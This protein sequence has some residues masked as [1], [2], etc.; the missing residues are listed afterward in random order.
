VYVRTGLEVADP[1]VARE[2]TLT[3]SA[4]D[5]FVAWLNGVEVGRWGVGPRP[6]PVPHDALAAITVSVE[7]PVPV[8]FRI[9]PKG[10]REGRN[11]VA[12]QGLNASLGSSDLSL[13]PVV[14]RRPES[15]AARDRKL[16]EDF[17]TA[18]GTRRPAVLAYLEGRALER[19]GKPAEAEDRFREAERLRASAQEASA[20]AS[21]PASSSPASS[22]PASSSPASSSPAWSSPASSSPASSSPASS[23][24]Q[25]SP[26]RSPAQQAP[27]HQAPARQASASEPLLHLAGCLRETGRRE[28]AE[29]LLR[30]AIEGPGRSSAETWD[31]WVSMALVDLGRSPAQVL[32]AFPPE[33]EGTSPRAAD[34]RWLLDRL[35]R[36]EPIRIRC[37]GGE[38]RARDGSV[39]GADRFFTSGCRYSETPWEP[40]PPDVSPAYGG[41]I[42]G[43]DDDPLF[44]TER[45]FP[46]DERPPA[47][48]RVPLAPGRWRVT[49]HFA[50]VFL[51][52]AGLRTFD[53]RVE[54]VSVLSWYDIVAEAG[55]ATADRKEFEVELR[56]GFLDIEF[57]PQAE[58]PKVSAIEVRRAE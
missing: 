38:Y 22:S 24:Q 48:Y 13:I 55:F 33:A 25:S 7:P 44:Q 54:G 57:L 12:L 40:L 51:R 5:G 53:I 46:A 19:A 41:E 49:L 11:V 1:S 18:G 4:D 52:K 27:A 9:D 26:P 56:D 30:A 21:S 2:M 47:G 42:D 6:S 17:R 36:G 43:T 50:E 45:W 10:L 15:D 28:E 35:G 3:V 20:L 37:G 8:S 16:V 58:F 29:A 39:W 32:A 23:A 34:L 31:L 14:T